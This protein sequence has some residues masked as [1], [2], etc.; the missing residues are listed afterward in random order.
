MAY[1]EQ[2]ITQEKKGIFKGFRVKLSRTSLIM[3]MEWNS[4]HKIIQ[5]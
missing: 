4:I 3:I 2:I 5:K 1:D